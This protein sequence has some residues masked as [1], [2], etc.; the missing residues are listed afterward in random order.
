[1]ILHV[2]FL[3]VASVLSVDHQIEK[4][5]IGVCLKSNIFD[6]NG[7]GEV[8]MVVA[9]VDIVM[10]SVEPY[11]VLVEGDTMR[12]KVFVGILYCSENDRRIESR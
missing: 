2:V 7:E 11:H 4:S 1:M 9:P 8:R 12:N 10:F 5:C 6:T 3:S